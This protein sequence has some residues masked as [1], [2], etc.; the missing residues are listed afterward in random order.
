MGGSAISRLV[1]SVPSDRKLAPGPHTEGRSGLKS[2][3]EFDS[4]ELWKS[5]LLLSRGCRRRAGLSLKRAS[6]LDVQRRQTS[7]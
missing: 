3:L 6:Q 7:F 4:K 5:S 2:I 1:T